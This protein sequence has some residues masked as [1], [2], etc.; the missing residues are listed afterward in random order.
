MAFDS[1]LISLLPQFIKG[2]QGLT[3]I[4]E[5][6]QIQVDGANLQADADRGAGQQALQGGQYSAGVYRQAGNAAI[7]E[8]NYNVALN[9]INTARQNNAL[10]K[11]TIQVNSTNRVTQAKSGFSF[12]SKSY[13]AVQ[14]NVL[15]NVTQQVVQL[16]NS[17]KQREQQITYEGLLTNQAYEN[18]ARSAEYQGQAAQVAAENRARASEYSGEVASYQ[19][20]TK[21]A[22]NIGGMVT[23]LFDSFK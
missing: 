4:N 10:A 20:G 21:N 22:Q 9:Q 14:A 11:Q 23:N 1:N 5:G 7:A 18:K 12:G 8:A 6:A 2:F 15:D 13:L 3:L 16:R 19:A 17:A